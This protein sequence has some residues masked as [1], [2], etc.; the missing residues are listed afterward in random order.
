MNAVI[1]GASRA[2]QEHGGTLVGFR[3]GLEG[4]V[5]ND[6]V[7]ID[8]Q[9]SL[10]ASAVAG[11]MLGTSR[12]RALLDEGGLDRSV[13]NATASAPDGLI[14]VGGN[15]SLKAAQL[16]A[17]RSLTVAFVPATIDNDVPG[18]ERALG[19]DSAIAYAVDVVERLRITAAALPGR[20]FLVETLGGD[21]GNL[22]RAV[23]ASGSVETVL[24]PEEPIE[25]Q[26]VA[27]ALKRQA[28]SGAAIA[29]LCEGVGNAVHLASLLDALC[30]ARIRPTILGHAQRAADPSHFDLTVGRLAGETSVVE[31]VAGR[32]CFISLGADGTVWVRPL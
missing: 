6:V 8:A 27:D 11:T 24:T 21:N 17:T 7:T 23:A 5:G 4:L 18:T 13:A 29:I 31:F 19:F 9:T 16:L 14:I 2:L 25:L 30:D 1:H 12:S 20:A 10:T 28:E 15:G 3:R 26:L 32:S 22:A